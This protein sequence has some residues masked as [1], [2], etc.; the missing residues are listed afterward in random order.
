MSSSEH[1]KK[2]RVADNKHD[3]VNGIVVIGGGVAGVSCAKELAR[4]S[5]ENS[6]TLISATETLVAVISYFMII[7]Q[8]LWH[9][10]TFISI[11][12]RVLS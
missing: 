4:I 11:Q 5:S 7:L 3:Q 10:S 6:I 2:A 12:S 8:I 9:I 1:S